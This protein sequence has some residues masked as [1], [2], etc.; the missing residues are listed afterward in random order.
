MPKAWR[1]LISLSVG[2]KI[3]FFTRYGVLGAGEHMEALVFLGRYGNHQRGW[4][5][6]RLDQK[7][8]II[9]GSSK[10]NL[11]GHTSPTDSYP[12]ENGLLPVR[13]RVAL[14][15]VLLPAQSLDTKAL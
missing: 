9:F 5:L 3:H 8:V 7:S 11:C 15:L 10:T 4:S 6:P 2:A 1:R 14:L 13:P 12:R